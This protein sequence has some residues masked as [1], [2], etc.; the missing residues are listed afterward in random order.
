MYIEFLRYL[1]ILGDTA[2]S[3]EWRSLMRV[4]SHYT[5]SV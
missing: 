5:A 2:I 3:K 4:G 1:G